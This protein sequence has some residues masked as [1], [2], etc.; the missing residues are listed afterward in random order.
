VEARADS[1][2]LKLTGAPEPF[3]DFERRIAIRNVSD[4]DPPGWRTALF[5]T[6]P[7]TLERIG[8][9]VAYQRGER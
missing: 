4:P 1:Y 8:A 5:A 6:H 3:I 7:P 9:A 2:A